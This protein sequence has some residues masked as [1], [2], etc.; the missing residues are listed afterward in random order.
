MTH[1]HVAS[2]LGMSRL[3]YHRVESRPRQIQS[4]EIVALCKLFA[5]K[6]EELLGDMAPVYRLIKKLLKTEK[7]AAAVTVDK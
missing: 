5:A 2:L 3:Q 6:P 7:P 1:D 4:S